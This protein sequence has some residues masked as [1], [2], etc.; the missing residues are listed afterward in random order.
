MGHSTIFATQEM[1]YYILSGTPWSTQKY[2]WSDLRVESS[3]ENHLLLIRGKMPNQISWITKNLGS[4]F[5][6]DLFKKKKFPN[7]STNCKVMAVQKWLP[8]SKNNKKLLS[9][10]VQTC[11]IWTNF[12]LNRS[13]LNLFRSY[14]QSF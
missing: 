12:F 6:S 4:R 14:F 10:T 5:N 11:P 1:V 7:P 3:G 9:E 2:F 8:F 13:E